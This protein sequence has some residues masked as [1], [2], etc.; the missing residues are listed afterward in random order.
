MTKYCA[1]PQIILP[2]SKNCWIVAVLC[3]LFCI[4]DKLIVFVTSWMHGTSCMVIAIVLPRCVGLRVDVQVFWRGTCTLEHTHSTGFSRSCTVL[5]SSP[6]RP[7]LP[8]R[9]WPTRGVGWRFRGRH[10]RWAPR[11]SS[12]RWATSMVTESPISPR[13]TSPVKT[14]PFSSASAMEPS[15]RRPD[16]WRASGRRP[17]RSATSMETTSPTSP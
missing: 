10:F 1:V 16:T 11:R 3:V 9:R 14:S 8:R 12:S 2:P 7:S 17:S 6:W 4:V 13:Q 15:H 5:S